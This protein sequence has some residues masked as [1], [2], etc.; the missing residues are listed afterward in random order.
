[1]K[2]KNSKFITSFLTL[3]TLTSCS[4]I[5]QIEMSYDNYKDSI[6]RFIASNQSDYNPSDFVI[7]KDNLYKLQEAVEKNLVWR[8]NFSMA[9]KTTDQ[10]SLKFISPY[11]N[12]NQDI[13]KQFNKYLKNIAW[14]TDPTTRFEI[15]TDRTSQIEK[16]REIYFT[17]TKRF[18]RHERDVEFAIINPYDEI[19]KDIIKA[20][21]VGLIA[22][23]AIYENHLLL[24]NKIHEVMASE[25]TYE[26]KKGLEN[27]YNTL[28]RKLTVSPSHRVMANLS[29]LYRDIKIFEKVKT[30]TK[31]TFYID[32]LIEDTIVFN[33]ITK[34]FNPQKRWNEDIEAITKTIAEMAKTD[35]FQYSN[36]F[37]K[38]IKFENITN[39][40]VTKIHKNEK[41]HLK[42]QLMPLDIVF[43]HNRN[44]FNNAIVENFWDNIG[45][46]IG[47]WDEI[48][49]LGLSEHPEIAKY[50]DQ[51]EN[52][53]LS[54]LTT[55]RQGVVLKPL[56][57][58]IN[59]DDMAVIRKRDLNYQQK[60]QALILAMKNIGKPYDYK[61][62]PE[63][64]SKISFAQLVFDT[65]PATNWDKSFI[66]KQEAV[67]PYKVTQ[68]TG[69]N[70][71]FFTV[72]LYKNGEEVLE[73]LEDNF[74]QISSEQ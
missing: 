18:K 49:Q 68:R 54:F 21:K 57:S 5:E 3:A 50:R 26:V 8:K 9:K 56:A 51:I 38:S 65:F 28:V 40:A 27:Y 61:M 48:V 39:G 29:S 1:M 10:E 44:S 58:V 55:T 47:S 62:D 7:D 69:E 6:K 12:Q 52:Q 31:L 16:R 11:F 64:K 4:S 33:H 70:Q 23:I 24:K 25:N 32:P 14:V 45:I 66:Y 15:R 63:D 30:H 60:A 37:Q 72:L 43:T 53:K 22:N 20:I 34:K 59:Q 67:S 42:Y 74:R 46:W 73:D 2:F 17:G 41:E 36:Y 13:T 19:G 71:E 35:T